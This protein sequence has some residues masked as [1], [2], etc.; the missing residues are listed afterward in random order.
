MLKLLILDLVLYVKKE[1]N[2]KKK[3]AGSPLWMAPETLELKPANEKIDVFGFSI[4]FYQ[5]LTTSPVPYDV[6]IYNNDI[7]KFTHS[8][9]T[10]KT[11]PAIPP[12]L[13]LPLVSLLEEGW[14]HDPN[15]RPSFGQIITKLSFVRCTTALRSDN[16]AVAMWNKYFGGENVVKLDKFCVAVYHSLGQPVPDTNC[17]DD[18]QLQKYKC[19]MT[20]AQDNNVETNQGQSDKKKKKV[21][22]RCIA[23]DFFWFGLVR[24]V[25]QIHHILRFW[26]KCMLLLGNLGFMEIFHV[27][28]RFL[29]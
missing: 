7:L 16:D 10:K 8:I 9:I 13:P 1:P 21:V 27:I 6:S 12:N 29:Y 18:V 11:R 17:K 2:K 14:D 22:H 15:K 3:L 4:I 24:F 19:L 5:L 28:K 26:I 23:S 25:R 20:L